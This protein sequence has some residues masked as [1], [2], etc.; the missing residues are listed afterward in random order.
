[1]DHTRLPTWLMFE[2][3]LT[4]LLLG[5]HTESWPGPEMNPDIFTLSKL[6]PDTYDWLLLPDAKHTPGELAHI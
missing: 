2:D 1:M 6:M 5:S 4:T 3:I